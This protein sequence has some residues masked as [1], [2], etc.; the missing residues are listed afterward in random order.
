MSSIDATILTS[1]VEMP[2][3]LGSRSARIMVRASGDFASGTYT[4]EQS[5]NGTTFV[6]LDSSV[7]NSPSA[8]A[9]Y[10]S[11][12]QDCRGIVA[13]RVRMTTVASAGRLTPSL[14]PTSLEA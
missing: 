13:Y 6:S 2:V 5:A 8:G 12:A 9:A 4:I 1:V 14:H 11:P 3:P 7:S 10:L